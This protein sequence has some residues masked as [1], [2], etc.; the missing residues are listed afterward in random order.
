VE[1]NYSLKWIVKGAIFMFFG[2]L[3]SKILNFVYRT[4]IA[5][6]LGTEAYGLLSLGVAAFSIFVFFA[7]LG[8]EQGVERYIG[9]Y[10]DKPKYLKV[11]VSSGV[12][13]AFFSS[14]IFAVF[15]F[16]FSGKIS[17]IFSSNP[18][19]KIIIMIL[20][21]A[22][23][24]WAVGEV[25]LAAMRGFK[26]IEFAVF[27]KQFLEPVIKVVLTIILLFLGYNIFGVVWAVLASIV[28]SFIFVLVLFLR[29]FYYPLPSSPKEVKLIKTLFDFSWPLLLIGV[30]F[31]LLTWIDTLMIGYFKSEILVG[32]YNVAI[33]TAAL[34]LVPGAMFRGLFVPIISGLYAEKN[35]KEISSIFQTVLKWIY[36]LTFPLFV[37]MFALA[38]EIIVFLYG[39]PYVD[40]EIPFKILIAGNMIVSFFGLVGVLHNSIGTTKLKMVAN[41]LALILGVILNLLLI[42]RL[43]LTG[44]ALAT[45]I[46]VI[47][48]SVLLFIFIYKSLNLT[49]VSFSLLTHY[50]KVTLS[51]VFSF[52][53][54]VS[55]FDILGIAV[56]SW[57]LIIGALLFGLI[58]LGI[59]VL[60]KGF[61]EED[62]MIINSIKRKFQ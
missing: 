6:G 51:T 41:I 28:I 38:K 57:T 9:Y 37:F 17:P 34:L 2:L 29:K 52:I 46:S 54:M 5:R 21:F 32:I 43:G 48:S 45:A 25:L 18:D 26:K 58:Y 30:M 35:Y 23:P 8:M 44:A 39:A 40:A 50:L 31:T 15:L 11:V 22:I 60:F 12:K 20:S 4:I 33:P 13:V 42:P 27:F 55:F 56:E 1:G 36:L 24:F 47:F 62:K 16:F 10:K 53:L 7:S 14:I 3:F 59:F 49:M 61:R 19:L